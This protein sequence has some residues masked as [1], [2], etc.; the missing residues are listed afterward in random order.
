MWRLPDV[1]TINKSAM[2]CS[3]E[4]F[5][6]NNTAKTRSDYYCRTL[7]CANLATST[8]GPF[9]V[10]RARETSVGCCFFPRKAFRDRSPCS[11]RFGASLCISRLDWFD[12]VIVDHRSGGADCLLRRGLPAW[13][14]AHVRNKHEAD[15]Y[16]YAVRCTTPV[17]VSKLARVC[18]LVHACKTLTEQYQMPSCIVQ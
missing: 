3:I 7:T 13:G 2:V 16:A 5:P 15:L 12:W 1:C 17:W 4:P 18:I 10:V 6:F 8:L 9:S 14:V 11:E